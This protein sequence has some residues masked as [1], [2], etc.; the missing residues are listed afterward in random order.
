MV[1]AERQWVAYR[2]VPG[3][4]LTAPLPSAPEVGGGWRGVDLRRILPVDQLDPLVIDTGTKSEAA[5]GVHVTDGYAYVIATARDM[6]P[7]RLVLGA[8]PGADGVETISA[9]AGA[10][11]SGGRWRK[12]VAKSFEA[13]SVQAP[14][15]AE[16]TSVLSLMA[17]EHPPAEAVS[18]LC[19][20]IGIV[21]PNDP[22]PDPLDLQ[23][24]ARAQLEHEPA[25]RRERKRWFSRGG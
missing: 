3:A 5:I 13:W 7:V 17:P 10:T 23:S 25:A 24:V 18:W 8:V 15:Q 12:H 9:H 2:V 1:G 14:R 16:T 21:Q 19:A 11:G 20:L 4:M 22:I 6:E